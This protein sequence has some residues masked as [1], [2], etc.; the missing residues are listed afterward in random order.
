[1]ATKRLDESVDIDV[2]EITA[3]QS[4]EW[5]VSNTRMLIEFYKFNKMLWDKSHIKDKGLKPAKTAKAVDPLAAKFQTT[6]LWR[7]HK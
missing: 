4:P 7:T 3:E 5:S 2:A 1:M 6:S